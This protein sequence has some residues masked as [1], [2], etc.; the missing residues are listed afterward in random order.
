MR[1]LGA[2]TPVWPSSKCH[3]T[4]VLELW[5]LQVFGKPA[6]KE[7]WHNSVP[8]TH[9]V[10]DN[11]FCAVSSH[12]IAVVTKYAGEVIFFVILL[13]QMK[14]LD[15]HYRKVCEY[16][17]NIIHIKWNLLTILILLPVL[18]MPWLISG[19]SSSSCYKGTSQPAGMSWWSTPAEWACLSGTP[20]L[21]K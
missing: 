16:W 20:R 9:S 2:R 15:P 21:P 3:G 6:S 4:L 18:K 12:F 8:I 17:G 5:V 7:N 11:Q 14:K 13:H 10:H 19:T 1:V